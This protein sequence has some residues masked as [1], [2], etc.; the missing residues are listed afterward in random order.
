LQ[1]VHASLIRV[2]DNQATT[3]SIALFCIG[4]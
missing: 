1:S 3:E 2:G 4:D